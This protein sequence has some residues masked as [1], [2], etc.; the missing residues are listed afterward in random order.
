MNNLDPEEIKRKW[1]PILSNIGLTGSQ[2]D[3]IAQLSEYNLNAIYQTPPC[4]YP[5]DETKLEEDQFPSIL[6]T[7]MRV[8]AQTIGKDLVDVAPIG[9]MTR[10]ETERIRNEVKI[11]NRERKIE[12]VVD[13]K[14]YK[15]MKVEDHPDYK[16]RNPSGSLFYLDYKYWQM[17]KRQKRKK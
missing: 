3:N 14:E 2:L 12:S 1:A 15:E 17:Q 9:G 16:V 5:V 13:D 11:E 8:A 4:H 7:V 6:P 10:E